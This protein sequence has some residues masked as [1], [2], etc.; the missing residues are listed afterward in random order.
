MIKKIINIFKK[1]KNNPF[2]VDWKKNKR[3][4]LRYQYNLNENSIVFDLGG[5]EGEWARGIYARYSCNIFIFEPVR[6]YAK[7]LINN[8]APNK[9]ISVYNFG[10]SSA[11][12]DADIFINNNSSSTYIRQKHGEKIKLIKA[13]EFIK[14]NGITKIDL[15]KI[16]IEGGEYDL[17]EHLIE[18]GEIKKIKNIQVQFHDFVPNAKERMKNIQ[19][20]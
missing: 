17:L 12:C 19:K 1:Q 13:S 10:L 7:N 3:E 6:E 14:E 15:M 16:N 18:S 8:F 20:N 5:Y 4:F 11:T 9:K 2:V